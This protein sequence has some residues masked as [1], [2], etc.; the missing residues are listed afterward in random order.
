MRISDWSS[1]V[2]SSDLLGYQAP[3]N[4]LRLKV[5]RFQTA[6]AVP[7]VASKG[8]DRNDSPNIDIKWTDGVHLNMP[9]AGGW[10]GHVIGQYRQRKGT[11][12]VAHAPLD[13]NDPDSRGTGFLALENK[14]RLGPDTQRMLSL[15]WMHDSLAD[16]GLG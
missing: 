3:D 15:T 10:R 2:C 7:G 16:Q 14:Q 13:F 5:G 4:G 8:L 11:G 6:F 9:I 12:A 1:D